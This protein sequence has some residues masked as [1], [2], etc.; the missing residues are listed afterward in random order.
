[1][2]V[3][4]LGTRPAS[5]LVALAHVQPDVVHVVT[6]ADA[7]ARGARVV[8]DAAGAAAVVPH[9][10]PDPF[11]D[12]TAGRAWALALA[13]RLALR[14]VTVNLSGGTTVLQDAVRTLS[15][16]LN[17]EEIAVIAEPGGEGRVV[18]VKSLLEVQRRGVSC[19]DTP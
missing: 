1:M 18:R 16:L 19:R 8:L 10:L 3:T 5:V 11:A 13:P 12:F 14:A 15:T 17:A 2:L 4:P 6:G 7:W 9:V